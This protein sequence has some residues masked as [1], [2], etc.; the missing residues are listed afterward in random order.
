MFECDKKNYLSY[1]Y[2]RTCIDTIM[3]NFHLSQKLETTKK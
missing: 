3:T 2:S 1:V